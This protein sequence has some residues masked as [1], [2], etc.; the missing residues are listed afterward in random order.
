MLCS[1]IP[2]LTLTIKS[3]PEQKIVPKN[4]MHVPEGCGGGFKSK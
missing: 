2:Q 3:P 4:A 1:H